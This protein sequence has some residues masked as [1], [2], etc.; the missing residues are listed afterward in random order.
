M[1]A[2]ENDESPQYSR[3][4]SLHLKAFDESPEHEE[5]RSIDNK[6]K[7]TE[8]EQIDRQREDDENRLDGNANHPPEESQQ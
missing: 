3:E 8:C 4:K 5:Q 6:S 2:G 1:D 7:D